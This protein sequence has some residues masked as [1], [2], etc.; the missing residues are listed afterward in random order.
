VALFQHLK[1]EE[2]AGNLFVDLL[3][4]YELQSKPEIEHQEK[5]RLGLVP[6]SSASGPV[7]E[8][9]LVYEQDLEHAQS[10]SKN[11]AY[12]TALSSLSTANERWLTLARAIE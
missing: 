5:E 10:T 8:G 9:S 7:A 1:N 4:Y 6:P 2:L 3:Q 12:V 11:V